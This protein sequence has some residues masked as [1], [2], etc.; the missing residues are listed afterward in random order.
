MWIILF[1]L[2]LALVRKG[3]AAL[4]ASWR[5]LP[6]NNEDWIYY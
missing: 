1:I 3:L 4:A 5:A 2:V 6:R